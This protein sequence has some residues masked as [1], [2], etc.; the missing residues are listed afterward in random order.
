MGSDGNRVRCVA[1]VDL[2]EHG[3]NPGEHEPRR[4]RGCRDL[5]G[6][7]VFGGLFLVYTWTVAAAII[8]RERLRSTLTRSLSL[9]DQALEEAANS[10]RPTPHAIEMRRHAE[11]LVQELSDHLEFISRFGRRS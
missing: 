2:V 8:E 1:A 3:D 10:T 5:G 9:A 7:I 11:Q 4:S 6:A